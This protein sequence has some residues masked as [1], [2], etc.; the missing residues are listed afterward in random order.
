MM[1]VLSFFNTKY[2]EPEVQS[3]F[4]RPY[5]ITLSSWVPVCK[6]TALKVRLEAGSVRF[7]SENWFI[8]Y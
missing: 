1:R 5:F 2:P 3:L 6:H 7:H 8:F 4:E